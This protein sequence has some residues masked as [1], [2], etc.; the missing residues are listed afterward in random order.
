MIV[1]GHADESPVGEL[2]AA[3]SQLCRLVMVIGLVCVIVKVD[4]VP[5]EPQLA[6]LE[7]II[8]IA[9]RVTLIVLVRALAQLLKSALVST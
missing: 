7:G 8:V 1:S 9:G 5:A 4:G 3:V 6:A 2:S